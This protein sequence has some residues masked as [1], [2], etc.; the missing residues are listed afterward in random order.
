[1]PTDQ[2][3]PAGRVVLTGLG[4]DLA[5]LIA[6]GKLL[7]SPVGAPART[8]DRALVHRTSKRRRGAVDGVM[9]AL[10]G[11][12]EPFV[13][14]PLAGL[15]AGRWLA[16]GQRAE[17]ASLVA[18][19]LGSAALNQAAKLTVER[20]R[21]RFKLPLSRP[22]GS[23][24]PSSHVTMSLATYGA[25]ACLA[26]RRRKPGPPRPRPRHGA[27][28]PFLLALLLCTLIGISRV[29][30]GVH[31]PTD[32]LASMIGGALWLHTCLRLRAAVT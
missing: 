29:Y 31:R 22:S 15:V 21:P 7:N 27:L 2:S 14:Y 18:A 3:P 16:A 11:L 17:A 24:F 12:G 30:T 23:S 13:L 26:A 1:M 6:L 20:P 28:V 5:A 10:S 9:R 19:L 4:T 25:I 32:V 8:L